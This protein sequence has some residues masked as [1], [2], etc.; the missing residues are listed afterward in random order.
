MIFDTIK[1][2]GA[3]AATIPHFEAIRDFLAG[4]IAA[5]PDGRHEIDG[6][7]VFATISSYGTKRL[8]D[9]V[10]EAHRRYADIQILLEGEEGCGVIPGADWVKEN[11]PYDETRD[12]R[13][14]TTPPDFARFTLSPGLFAFFAPS[15]AHMPG[16]AIGAMHRVRKCVI[17]VAVDGNR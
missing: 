5:L 9:G 15:D 12:I 6:D 2:V 10:F 16:I 17:K 4:D 11:V 14:L 13:F 7:R 3:Y 8:E 1:N